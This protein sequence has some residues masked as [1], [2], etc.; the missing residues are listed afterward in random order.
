[1]IKSPCLN[2]CYIDQTSGLCLGC[3]RRIDEI[4][5]WKSLS[6]VEKKNIIKEIKIRNTTN[7]SNYSKKLQSKTL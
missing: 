1:M 2:V 4:S 6:S 3:K 7:I 5:S